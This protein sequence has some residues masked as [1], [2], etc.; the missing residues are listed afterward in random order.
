MAILIVFA[1]MLAVS[2][3]PV[4]TAENWELWSGNRSI[5]INNTGGSALTDYQINL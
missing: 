3:S 1:A 4:C 2:I 5:Y